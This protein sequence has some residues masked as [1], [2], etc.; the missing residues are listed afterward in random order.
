MKDLTASVYT[1]EDLILGNYLYVDKTAQL[2]ELV[3]GWK[4]IYFLSRP[5]RFGKSLTL[6]TLKA[7]FQGRRELFRGLAIDGKPYGWKTHPVIHLDFN[8]RRLD[9]VASLEESMRDILE[10][11]AQANHVALERT[12]SVHMFNRLVDTLART[13]QVVVL[14]DEYDKPVLAHLDDAGR[15]ME[16][17]AALKPFYSVLKAREYQ[18]R[19]VFVTGVSKFCHVSLFSDLNNLQDIST[20]DR[21][22]TMLGYTQEELEACFGERL[23]QLQAKLSLSREELLTALKLWYDGY[24]FAP[25]AETVYNPVSVASFF[26]RGGRFENYWFATGTTSSL[27]ALMRRDDASLPRLMEQPVSGDLFDSFDLA[28]VNLQRLMYQTGYLTIGETEVLGAG[29]EEMER[30]YHLRFPNKEVRSSFNNQVMEHYAGVSPAETSILTRRLVAD[31][32]S[33]D[34]DAFMNRLKTLF[35]RIPY[36]LHGRRERDYQTVLYVILLMLKVHIHGEYHTN[37]GSIDLVLSGGEWTYVIELKLNKTAEK[38]MAQIMHK[39]Y[40]RGFLGQGRRVVAVG[41]NFDEK[42]AQIENWLSEEV[43]A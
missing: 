42:R 24:R 25:D 43:T 1:F 6:S 35:A 33:G 21:F 32:R 15:G 28:A 7:V 31:V 11:Q 39:D 17:L 19:F 27:F 14:V 36:D 2:W 10:E 26:M 5:R 9:T 34:V 41:V 20:D 13:E 30:F 3:N 38:A 40:A 23:P 29:T 22:A 18:L 8:G 16:M 12:D 4:G 37:E